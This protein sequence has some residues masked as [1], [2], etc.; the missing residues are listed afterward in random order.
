MVDMSLRSEQKVKES[1]TKKSNL[2]SATHLSTWRE[3][4]YLFPFISFSSLHVEKY[5]TCVNIG[6]IPKTNNEG[7]AYLRQN[8]DSNSD[9]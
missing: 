8:K 2:E 9:K 5:Y 7:K 4:P 3:N 1:K 6:L